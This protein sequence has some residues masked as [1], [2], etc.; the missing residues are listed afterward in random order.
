VL[1]TTST[2]SGFTSN[3][4]RLYPGCDGEEYQ[5]WLEIRSTQIRLLD[6]GTP[7]FNGITDDD[8]DP[9]N[10]I[11]ID[12]VYDDEVH[13]MMQ[14]D[15][16]ADAMESFFSAYRGRLDVDLRAHPETTSAYYPLSDKINLYD[17]HV[18]EL[19]YSNYV[20][21]HEFGH[22][23]HEKALGGLPS[24]DPSCYEHSMSS[25]ELMKCAYFEGFAAY[26]GTVVGGY[27]TVNLENNY[28]YSSGMDGSRVQGPI[29]AFFWDL[30]DSGTEA[31]DAVSF[32]GSYVASIISSCQVNGGT[33]ANGIDHLIYCFENQ[34]DS[35]V[36]SDPDY[37]PSRSS[38][39]TSYSESAS[40]PYGWSSSV[41]RN[42]W[43][44]NLY[45]GG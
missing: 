17:G 28:F 19:G 2:E 18:W 10:P 5:G 8:C 43:V 3:S 39:P 25:V 15:S 30:T 4:G 36:T 21:G 14:M 41:I 6:G 37:F 31:H 26:S 1:T 44:E 9:V 34:I 23:L 24:T 16:I 35:L 29:A 7:G 38:D 12:A 22:A 45:G 11:Q 40:E 32:P 20:R 27:H 42:L 13:V 33:R